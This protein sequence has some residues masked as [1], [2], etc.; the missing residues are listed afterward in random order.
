[1]IDV[2]YIQHFNLISLNIGCDDTSMHMYI[3]ICASYFYLLPL[4]GVLFASTV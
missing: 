1:V 3:S 2:L 4:I